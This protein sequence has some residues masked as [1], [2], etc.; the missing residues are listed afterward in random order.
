MCKDYESENQSSICKYQK[1]GKATLKNNVV[2]KVKTN[3]N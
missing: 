2:F 3:L 1:L